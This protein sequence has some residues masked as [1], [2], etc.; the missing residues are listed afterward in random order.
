VFVINTDNGPHGV[1]SM[2]RDG[3]EV[4]ILPGTRDF[5]ILEDPGAFKSALE[6]VLNSLVD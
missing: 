5:L 2:E 3:V 6:T 1:K 4:Q